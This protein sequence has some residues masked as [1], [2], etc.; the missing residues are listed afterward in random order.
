MKNTTPQTVSKFKLTLFFSTACLYTV[1][2]VFI[3]LAQA[4]QSLVGPQKTIQ[5]T[6]DKL[7]DNLG[8]EPLKSSFAEAY[9]FVDEVLTPHID[10]Y[11]I[12]YLALG[13]HWKLASEPQK[14]QF[15]K[16]FKTL[17]M[18]TYTRTFLE[19]ADWS[20]RYLPLSMKDDKTKAIVRTEVIQTS[21]APLPVSYRMKL[22]DGN[23]QVY[24]VIT[25]GVSLVTNYRTSFKNEIR[26]DGSIDS[27]I[28]RLNELNKKAL[29][30]NGA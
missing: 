16:A 15:Q 18:R 22:N 17:I 19:Y 8:K 9:Q 27:I 26:R 21:A 6:S 25:D 24:D 3:A 10:I 2:Y 20:I 1:L 28:A 29:M 5:S 14:Q 23:W 12:S 30:V 4:D 7:Q 13:K 11:R